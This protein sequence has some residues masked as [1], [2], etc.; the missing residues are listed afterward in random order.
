MSCVGVGPVRLL[1]FPLQT[2]VSQNAKRSAEPL[3]GATHERLLRLH[4]LRDVLLNKSSALVKRIRS[5]GLGFLAV[6][7]GTSNLH[8]FLE[9]CDLLFQSGYEKVRVEFLVYPGI[10]GDLSNS[11]SKA[12]CG[13]RL[14]DVRSLCSNTAD[15]GCS[16]IA[17]Q[18]VAKNTG[19]HGVTVRYMCLHALGSRMQGHNDPLQVVQGQVNGLRFL[20]KLPVHPGLR[21]SLAAC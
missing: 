17:T 19:H 18:R 5:Q 4:T 2:H 20:Q 21:D 6:L 1:A 13:D 14:R 3:N 15:H 11:L 12:A 10:V 8:L 9:L 7:A 16:T